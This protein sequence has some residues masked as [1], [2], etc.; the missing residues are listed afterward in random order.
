MSKDDE[1]AYLEYCSQAMFRIHILELRLNRLVVIFYVPYLL[2]YK[3]GLSFSRMST[4]NQI[5][6]MQFCC[7]TV[8]PFLNNPKDLDP[9]YKTDLDFW[10]GTVL[11]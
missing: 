9:S 11:T 3:T 4:N 6:P 5:S 1:E 8:L 7:N 2:G 10:I